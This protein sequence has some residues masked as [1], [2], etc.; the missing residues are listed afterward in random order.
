MEIVQIIISLAI[1]AL[2]LIQE[3]SS[4]FSALMGGDG[5]A[6]QTRRGVEKGAFYA[7]IALAIIFVVIA[8]FQLI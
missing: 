5:A 3:R 6:Y 8:V 7:T 4:G 1:I 2:I